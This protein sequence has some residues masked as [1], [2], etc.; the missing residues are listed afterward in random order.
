MKRLIQFVTITLFSFTLALPVVAQPLP[1]APQKLT[2][3]QKA[4]KKKEAKAAIK[5]AR[6]ELKAA[7]KKEKEERKAAK[8]K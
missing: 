3:E 2:S 6:E 8:K 4:V 7:E 1:A 5:K